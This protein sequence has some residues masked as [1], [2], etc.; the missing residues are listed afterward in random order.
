[1]LLYSNNAVFRDTGGGSSRSNKNLDGMLQLVDTAVLYCMYLQSSRCASRGGCYY[2]QLGLLTRI[3][4][5]SCY[6]Q[7]AY[8]PSYC[9]QT[10]AFLMLRGQPSTYDVLLL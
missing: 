7:L 2:H 8:S 5:T 3:A 10:D 9:V 1:M 6:T 4:R